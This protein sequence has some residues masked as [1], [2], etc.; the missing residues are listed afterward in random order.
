MDIVEIIGGCGCEAR[1]IN[2]GDIRVTCDA[3]LTAARKLHNV[4]K[5]HIGE[6][7]YYFRSEYIDNEEKYHALIMIDKG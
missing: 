1:K 4:I 7:L 3:S 6:R 5:E 2:N